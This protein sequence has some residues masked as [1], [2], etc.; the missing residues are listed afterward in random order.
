MASAPSAL[1][2]FDAHGTLGALSVGVLISSFLF[3][4]VTV[5]AY[6]YYTRF[7]EDQM[8]LKI[9]VAVVWLFELAHCISICH[10]LYSLTISHY[11]DPRALVRPPST[12]F[13]AII[14]SG[15]IGPL[16]QAFFAERVRVVSGQLIIPIICW[17]LSAVRLAMSLV[18]ASE[19]F[20]MTTLAQYQKEWKWLLTTVLAIG[21]AVDII[22]AAALCY[23]LRIQRSNSHEKTAMMIDKIIAWTIQTGLMTSLTGLVMLICFLAMPGNFVWLA[24]FMFLA[25]MF[26]NSLLASLNA[27]SILRSSKF[28]ELQQS[29]GSTFNASNTRYPQSQVSVRMTKLTE[30]TT[31]TKADPNYND[32]A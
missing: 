19:A 11:G 22:V 10:S 1:A 17:T 5:Q 7:P 8:K 21:A 31:D 14:F 23:H 24:F 25:R 9:L 6:V 4:I 18:A 28:V 32:M 26:S 13:L 16:V 27:R 15:V 12:L 30:V 29:Q 20:Q 3:G 2:A